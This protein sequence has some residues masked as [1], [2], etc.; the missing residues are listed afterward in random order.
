MLLDFRAYRHLPT[1]DE[2]EGSAHGFDSVKLLNDG[3]AGI[4]PIAEG[5]EVYETFADLERELFG[6]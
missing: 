4:Y 3:P 6:D 5:D 2:E 1:I